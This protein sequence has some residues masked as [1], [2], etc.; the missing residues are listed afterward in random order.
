M[1]NMLTNCPNCGAALR[2]DGYCEYCK[3]KIRYAN[4]LEI[5]SGLF[6]RCEVEIL[7]KH[8]N[9]DG[10]VVVAPFKGWLSTMTVTTG[11][12]ADLFVDGMVF[13]RVVSPPRAELTFEGMLG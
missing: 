1:K 13:H 6:D 4:E 11:D 10:T 2:S 8:H 3:T 7:L 9:G 12:S 5:E